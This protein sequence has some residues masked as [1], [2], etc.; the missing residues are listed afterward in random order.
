MVTSMRRCYKAALIFSVIYPPIV[1]LIAFVVRVEESPVL[2]VPFVFDLVW[3]KRV[4]E[5][6]EEDKRWS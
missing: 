3:W 4:R 6:S 1:V 2:N 5:K